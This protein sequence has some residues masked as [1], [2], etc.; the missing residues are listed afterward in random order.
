MQRIIA[1]IYQEIESHPVRSAWDKGVRSYAE[2]LFETY[3][4][5]MNLRIDDAK[6]RIGKIVDADLLN[7]ARDWSQYSYGVYV[8]LE[9]LRA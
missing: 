6:T 1:E 8:D 7:G 2:E 9:K 4:T 3:I 5:N